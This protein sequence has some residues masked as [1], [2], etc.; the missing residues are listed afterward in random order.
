MPLDPKYLREET[1]PETV[2]PTYKVRL[3][4]AMF[5]AGLICVVMV[6][7]AYSQGWVGYVPSLGDL[8]HRL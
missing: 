8:L 6:F 2:G 7:A 1:D 4:L 3:A 5:I